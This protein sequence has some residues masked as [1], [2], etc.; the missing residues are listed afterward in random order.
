MSDMNT[1]TYELDQEWLELMKQAKEM[2]LSKEEVSIF[3]KAAGNN[4][5]AMNRYNIL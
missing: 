4:K 1:K 2:G 3:L 5:Q